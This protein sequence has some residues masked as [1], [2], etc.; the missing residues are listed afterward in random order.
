[1]RADPG[2]EVKGVYLDDEASGFTVRDNLFLRVD[3][4]VFIGGGRDNLVPGERLRRVQPRHPRGLARADL[5]RQA[6]ADP[7]SDIRKAYAAMPVTSA[8]WRRRY[9]GLADILADAPAVAKRNR[10][11]DNVFV[12]SQPFRFNDGGESGPQIISGNVGPDGMTS[13]AGGDLAR[14][15]ATSDRREDF[16]ALVG[17]RGEALPRLAV[18]GTRRSAGPHFSF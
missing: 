7:G 5:G 3:Q 17:P 13:G 18:S 11:E 10:L 6:I 8:L 9:P 1:M 4:A 2:F 12:A 15:A 16:E 14:L